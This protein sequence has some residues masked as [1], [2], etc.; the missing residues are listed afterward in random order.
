MSKGNDNMNGLTLAAAVMATVIT[1]Y[2]SLFAYR[3]VLVVV[4]LL[5]TRRFKETKNRH[6]YA[7]LIAAR[8]EETVIGHLLDSIKKQD[9]PSSLVTVFVVADNCQDKTAT[10]AI[11][12]GA[13][14]Y[15]RF[16]S[17]HCTKGYALQFLLEQI[18]RDYGIKAFEAYLIF[19]ADNLLKQDYLSRMNEAFDAGEKIVTSYRNTKN[20]CDNWI[21]ASYGLHWMRTIRTEHR[22]RST[23]RLATRIQGTGFLFSNE[24][25]EN[26]W[27]YTSLTEDRAFCADAVVGNYRI[28][29]NDAAEF[30]DEQPTNLRIALR[31]RIR[32][33][34]GHLQAFAESGGKLFLKIFVNHVPTISGMRENSTKATTQKAKPADALAFRLMSYDML[35]VTM[36]HAIVKITLKL[37][38]YGLRSVMI[39][40]V[41]GAFVAGLCP[42]FLQI[43][44]DLLSCRITPNT[45]LSAWLLLTA[46]LLCGLVSDYFGSL[47]TG[48]YIMITE[49]RH[50]PPLPIAKRLWYLLT[51][52]LFDFIGDLAMWIALFS[53][54]EW[55]PIPHTVDRTITDMQPPAPHASDQ[56]KMPL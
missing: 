28:S 15:E 16:D 22:A 19:D 1:V 49:R 37:I 56:D 7:V 20:F 12:N 46:F 3:A 45:A 41:G 40:T 52:P 29:Y 23:M 38:L 18:D 54:V 25:V 2:G 43:F 17:E 51:F 13:V 48:V 33:A 11:E 42:S 21:A 30:Y 14:C 53:K 32:W 34:K 9:Y 55:K 27:H 6:R 8:N 24:I 10:V 39:F 31:Q 44:L 50:I 4:G 47:F 35:T 26:G 5:T 36:P